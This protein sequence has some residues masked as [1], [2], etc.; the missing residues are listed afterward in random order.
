MLYQSIS[1]PA[2]SKLYL[3]MLESIGVSQPDTPEEAALAALCETIAFMDPSKFSFA[4]IFAAAEAVAFYR[5]E[6]IFGQPVIYDLAS[7]EAAF[8]S[9]LAVMALRLNG[10]TFDPARKRWSDGPHPKMTI[11]FPPD[12]FS[13]FLKNWADRA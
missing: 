12:F 8:G 6:C 7:L 3:A 11:T 5:D 4:E 13:N 9:D 1:R 2:R 10:A